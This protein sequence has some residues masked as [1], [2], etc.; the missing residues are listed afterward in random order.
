MNDAEDFLYDDTYDAFDP[1]D[2][3]DEY[4]ESFDECGMTP[5]GSCSLAGTEFCDF[6]C[7]IRQ[8]MEDEEED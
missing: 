3:E 7:K 2:E 6:D 1:G 8:A 4:D 5:D